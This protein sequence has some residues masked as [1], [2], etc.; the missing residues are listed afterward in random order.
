MPRDKITDMTA[1]IGLVNR[2]IRLVSD[3]NGAVC[4]GT[5]RG[6]VLKLIDTEWEASHNIDMSA[7][8]L[9]AY[10]ADACF[11]DIAGATS[12][13]LARA[14]LEEPHTYASFLDAV[15]AAGT[16]GYVLLRPQSG[17]MPD[18]AAKLLS[19]PE[20]GNVSFHARCGPALQLLDL[21][22]VNDYEI[23]DMPQIEQ[24]ITENPKILVRVTNN[25]TGVLYM[26]WSHPTGRV[27]MIRAARH[28]F[29]DPWRV[30]RHPD[31]SEDIAAAIPVKLA[32]PL[33]SY[34]E[35]DA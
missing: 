15:R 34:Y 16:T 24:W 8:G 18:T 9:E 1:S 28:D 21:V 23:G 11:Q 35:T 2:S 10:L 25:D 6:N 30:I 29:T 14:S 13:A 17:I 26:G 33:F 5:V 4:A 19:W 32:E 3:E 31:G 7:C 22:S 20:N 27:A 12:M